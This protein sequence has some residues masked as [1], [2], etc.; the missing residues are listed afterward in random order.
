VLDLA[1]TAMSRAIGHHLNL[2]A[3]NDLGWVN[4]RCWCAHGRPLLN[5]FVVK[6]SRNVTDSSDVDSMEGE[7]PMPTDAAVAAH[8][9]RRAGFGLSAQQLGEATR[10]DYADLV[11]ELI[12]A[13][14][15]HGSAWSFLDEPADQAWIQTMRATWWWLDHMRTTSTPMVE[16]LALFWHGY[17]CSAA[18]KCG[19]GA[20]LDQQRLFRDLGRANFVDLASAVC[21]GAAMTTYLDNDTNVVGKAQENLAREVFELFVLGAGNFSQRDV[22]EAARAWTGHGAGGWSNRNAVYYRDGHFA[23]EHHDDSDKTILGRQAAFGGPDVIAHAINGPTRPIAAAH[24]AGC[25]W[26]FFA[27][28][29]GEPDAISAVSDALLASNFSIAAAMKALLLHPSFVSARAME[30]Q[31]LSPVELAVNVS[32]HLRLDSRSAAVHEHLSAMGQSPFQPPDVFGWPTDRQWL[33]S[34]SYQARAAF[35]TQAVATAQRLGRV[36]PI[37]HLSVDSAV[38]TLMGQFALTGNANGLRTSVAQWLTNARARR[39]EHQSSFVALHIALSP[40]YH[41]V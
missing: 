18:D 38:D 40:Q 7:A 23:P 6:G 17:F 9:F 26:S 21:T 22:T 30:G 41:V 1:A 29:D 2:L 24:L 20:M 4:A 8:L 33:S 15:D 39:G 19:L 11:D 12:N 35:V 5:N 27:Y 28:R 3:N 32:R 34:A 31:V 37:D 13:R 16:K 14:P 36:A 10:R 25:L